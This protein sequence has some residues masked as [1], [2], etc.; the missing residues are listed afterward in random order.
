MSQTAFRALFA[1]IDPDT[2]FSGPGC[3][4][5]VFEEP[6]VAARATLSTDGGQVITDIFALD[7]AGFNGGT[8]DALMH[9]ILTINDVAALADTF[10]VG[11]DSRNL[12]V[13]TGR[14]RL[15]GLTADSYGEALSEWLE[16]VDSLRAC[17]DAIGL[18]AETITFEYATTD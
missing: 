16:Q 1:E 18:Q 6:G 5:M 12:L 2:R 3:V 14:I 11:I 10:T 17:A 8:R 4:D 9:A 7:V 15:E 13:L